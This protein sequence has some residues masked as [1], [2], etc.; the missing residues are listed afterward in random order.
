MIT[1]RIVYPP[2]ATN[3]DE[4]ESDFAHFQDATIPYAAKTEN[5]ATIWRK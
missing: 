3:L 4:G 1:R 5:G 2:C